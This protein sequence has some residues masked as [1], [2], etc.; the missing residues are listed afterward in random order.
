V[1]SVTSICKR[2]FHFLLV[3]IFSFAWGVAGAA[4][5]DSD[6]DALRELIDVFE[7]IKSQYAEPIDEKKLAVVAIKA[8]I[9]KL[10]PH[11]DYLDAEAYD[12]LQQNIRGNFGGL[13]MEVGVQGNSVEVLSATE[14][15]PAQRA[16]LR[17]G[18]RITQIG[19]IDVNATTLEQAIQRSRGEPGT[20]V[21]VTVQGKDDPQPRSITLTRALVDLPYVNTALLQGGYAHVRISHFNH[22]TAESVLNGLA[23]LAERNEAPLQGII[24]DLR[25]NPGGVLKA[26]VA[27][28]GLFLEEEQLVTYTDSAAE[29]SRM[30]FVARSRPLIE[31]LPAAMRSK[32]PDLKTVP[33]VVLVNGGSASASE[34]VAGALQDHRRAQ[35]AGTRTYGKGSVQ[36]VIALSSGSALK[37]TTA[38]YHTP[39]GRRIHGTGVLPD[40]T[41][42][43]SAA[44]NSSASLQNISND[45]AVVSSGH[46][47]PAQ[48]DADAPAKTAVS[49]DCQLQ[50]ALDLL[51]KLHVVA[52]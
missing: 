7:Q 40:A 23:R 46:C 9:A 21:V 11:S 5:S 19:D 8:M 42:E 2:K 10:D 35:I 34:V 1:C 13:G 14:D 22:R 20:Q 27:V 4:S 43:Q 45:K 31:K 44:A 32:L 15:S 38:Y 26:G 17:P 36:A 24:L 30:A 6:G 50:R 48:D 51:R 52:R 47:L 3:V 39:N 33:L 12:D 29:A 49:G 16:G 25:D 41:I 37:L 18:D 28:A